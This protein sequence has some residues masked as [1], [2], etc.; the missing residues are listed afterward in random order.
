MLTKEKRAEFN[1]IMNGYTSS[2]SF[3]IAPGREDLAGFDDSELCMENASVLRQGNA[4]RRDFD[5]DGEDFADDFGLPITP[6]TEDDLRFLRDFILG[7]A[8]Y[9]EEL[10]SVVYKTSDDFWEARE[11]AYRIITALLIRH[12]EYE[13]EG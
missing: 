11:H 10:E 5:Y 6:F 1:S 4:A 7:S 2:P 3:D 13:M 9:V 12:Y 8:M